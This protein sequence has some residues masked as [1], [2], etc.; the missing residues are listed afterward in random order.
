MIGKLKNLYILLLLLIH[1]GSKIFTL[2]L[3]VPKQTIEIS[4]QITSSFPNR[5][6][7]FPKALV[8]GFLPLF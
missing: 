8:S 3:L 5:L 7:L 1:I 2:L 4:S 6:P